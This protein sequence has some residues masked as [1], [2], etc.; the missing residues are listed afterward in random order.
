MSSENLLS[1]PLTN[2]VSFNNMKYSLCPCVGK[3][4]ALLVPPNKYDITVL[5]TIV[6]KIDL[7]YDFY[8]MV[9]G[10]TPSLYFKYKSY[11][12]IAVT[13]SSCGAGCGF[14]GFTGIEMLTEYFDILY[15]NVRDNNLYDQVVFYEMGRNFWFY[16]NNIEYAGIDEKANI[17]TGYAVFMRFA[18][19]E[20]AGVNG[21]DFG[22][23]PFETFKQNVKNQFPAYLND[24]TLSWYN[25]FKLGR[26]PNGGKSTNFVASMLFE[27]NRIFG[28][29]FAE[30]T[31]DSFLAKLWREVGKT[32][33]KTSTQDAI[34]NLITAV[35]NASGTDA[36]QLF[37]DW[38][39]PVDDQKIIQIV[40][41]VIPA[42]QTWESSDQVFIYSSSG[43]ICISE[44][45][46]HSIADVLSDDISGITK[47]KLTIVSYDS[48]VVTSGNINL[49][50]D[51]TCDVQDE[52]YCLEIGSNINIKSNNEAGL[53][54]GTR[55]VLQL[56]KQNRIILGGHATDF[57]D[58]Q[59]RSYMIDNGRKYFTP[60][61]LMNKI[62]EL[63]YLK[64]N[65]FHWH[66]CDR[67]GFRLESNFLKTPTLVIKKTELTTILDLA[68]K[69]FI[70][71]VPE[72]EMPGHMG[73]WVPVEHRL[74][75]DDGKVLDGCLNIGKDESIE[76][77]K[78]II[79][80]YLPF[81]TGKYIHIGGDEFG[82]EWNR[83]TK[84]QTYIQQKLNNP[85]AKAIDAFYY[86]VNQ[87]NQHIKNSGKITRMWACNPHGNVVP[88]ETDIV[89]EIWDL[90]V[91]PTEA[92][93][94]GFKIMNCSFYPTYYVQGWEPAR[95]HYA[96]FA[97]YEQW[98]STLF[99]LEERGETPL[100]KTPFW[101]VLPNQ[102]NGL[103]G[104]KMHV[105]S[106]NPVIETEET[107]NI[108][109]YNNIRSTSQVLWGSPKIVP[110]F[111]DFA[112]LIRLIGDHPNVIP[113]PETPY[114]FSGILNNANLIIP[115]N[116]Y[117]NLTGNGTFGW[118]TKMTRLNVKLNHYTFILDNGGGNPLNY[119][120]CIFGTGSLNL[121]SS[122]VLSFKLSGDK[123]NTFTGNTTILRGIVQ[124]AKSQN[125]TAIPGD[126]IVNNVGS[127]QVMVVWNNSYQ[128]ASTSNIKINSAKGSIN[129]GMYQETI[130][131]LDM[132]KGSLIILSNNGSLTVNKMR[133]DNT[134]VPQGTYT[135]GPFIKGLGSVIV[136][137][138]DAPI[139][140]P[141][142]IPYSFSGM[143]ANPNTVMQA[144]KK[145]G[146][147]I[148]NGGFGWQTGKTLVNV[149]LNG[150]ELTFDN[151]N[152]NMFNYA[153]AISGNGKVIIKGT[154]TKTAKPT[155][156]VLSGNT[157]N[158]FVGP[159]QV[160]QGVVELAKIDSIAIP[161]DLII[162][163]FANE[164]IRWTQSNQ[165]APNSNIIMNCKNG[166]L[167]IGGC[168]DAVD[169]VTMANG[170]KIVTTLGGV[171]KINKLIYDDAHVNAG[172]YGNSDL[173]F[174]I[175]DGTVII[176]D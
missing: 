19:M 43:N 68:K 159:L 163:D 173:P 156:L 66:L 113:N 168:Q 142:M 9:T 76:F 122:N 57:P 172:T 157:S 171:L 112:I 15:K 96:D 71:I 84:V 120:G 75:R 126:L 39:F 139:L 60:E 111:N 86:F 22:G 62:K 100:E 95:P 123:P 108:N 91:N 70:T 118:Q 164:E 42:L 105:W 36:R 44:D 119:A 81:F 103:L 45:T 83:L 35:S 77:V 110:K 73:D 34:N 49:I 115:P 150:F 16:R 140:P 144:V 128:L 2:Y 20:Y 82:V 149:V 67:Q 109:T 78:K 7:A 41:T 88:L 27:L 80:E 153:G 31:S 133:Y 11:A 154:S 98:D 99:Y 74:V 69:Y 18:S 127:G 94:M 97:I 32:P 166:I 141:V 117:G 175:G 169:N 174:I 1:E 129:I 29:P 48:S 56:L 51:Q 167:N 92:I 23:V 24:N 132:I 87:M 114:N 155:P 12:T 10:Q 158:T 13:A 130:D 135:S 137:T 63:S 143:I 52:G 26:S 47:D 25:T 37:R 33:K 162:N 17:T 58:N 55:T 106:D 90:G 121:I 59:E 38:K 50:L 147:L 53:F 151:G 134:V 93:N 124:L 5:S 65:Y 30:T 145:Y 40:P 8:S 61:W 104:G 165:F 21:S 46:L 89:L 28:V 64:F 72:Y 85:G 3:N 79:N 101:T 4:I 116:K 152:G 148:G 136:M 107:V 125:V 170:S 160:I 161:G 176:L 54:W 146:M 138:T 14:L 6:S 102:Y 131:T